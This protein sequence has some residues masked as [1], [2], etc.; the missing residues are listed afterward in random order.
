MSGVIA[1]AQIRALRQRL[2]LSQVELAAILGVSN[3]TVNRWEHE[4]ALPQGGMSERLL[5]LER[6]GLDALHESAP[7]QRGNLPATFSPLVGRDADLESVAAQI[8]LNPLLTIVGPA[9]AGKTRLAIESGR[10]AAR[11]W[12]D[13]I[14]FVDLAAVMEP[15]AVIHAVAR[16][17][18][19]REVGR[20][21]LADRLADEF[22][23]R[24]LLLILDNCEHLLTACA[25]LVSPL[26][27]SE[28]ASRLLATS[29]VPL[30]APGEAVHVLQPLAPVD[31]IALF[32]QRARERLP[33]LEL[34][35]EQEQ[36]IAEICRRLDGL[37]LAIELAA[38]RTH[39]LSVEQIAG[40]LDRRFDLLRVSSATAPRQRALDMAIGWSYDLLAPAEAALFRRLGAFAGWCDLPAVEAV[41]ERADAIDLLD[42]LARQ[43]MI[44]VA[45]DTASRSARYRLLESLASYARRELEQSG[46]AAA[47]AARHAEYYAGLAQRLSGGLRGAS[48]AA[49]FAALDREYDNLIAALE[50]TLT[51]H[52]SEQA[53]V[54]AGALGSYWDRRGRYAEGSAWLE[55]SL[56]QEPVLPSAARA[57]AMNQLGIL[58]NLTG[59]LGAAEQTLAAAIDLAREI[60]D[61]E[62]EAR[63]LD[64]L[65]LVLVARREFARAAECHET[66]MAIFLA[67]GERGRAAMS[68]KHLGNIANLRGEYAVS[69]RAYHEAWSLVQG[70]GDLSA[71]AVIL[72]NLGD[73]ASRIGRYSRALGYFE[74]A[75]A[76]LRMIGDPDR[77]AADAINTA[78]VKIV[79]GEPEAALPLA[80]D[81]V[82]QFRAIGNKA[83]LANALYVQGAALAAVGRRGNGLACFRESLTLFYQLDDWI[84]VVYAVE[85][86]ARL[87]AEGGDASFA[88]LLLGGADVIRAE[89]QVAPYPLF[90]AAGTLAVIRAALG[91]DGMAA[92]WEDGQSLA[93]EEARRRGVAGR[94][95]GGRRPGL[96]ADA[97]ASPTSRAYGLDTLTPRQIDVLRLV[98]AGSSNREIGGPLGISDRTVERHLTAIFSALDVDRRSSAVA[99]AGALG[100]L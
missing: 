37:P 97:G 68:R 4:R 26:I 49:L 67:L 73:R 50:W 77:L 2:G 40:R 94:R 12:R 53:V 59:R 84:D 60:G 31:A 48:Q 57:A 34:D 71:E 14:W 92:Q 30:D 69:E 41:A 90:D 43:S 76:V 52:E 36:A 66:A 10:L 95:A 99:K 85:V 7:A 45:H 64:T 23:D 44:V 3:V 61:R 82:T 83:S 91:T 17:L 79:L 78:E 86:I 98:A 55:R 87:F 96:R 19:V 75:L 27:A 93:R 42:G 5:R 47:A 72:S 54:L 15:E 89:E 32:V 24:T 21:S 25:A 74:R 62:Q 70:T 46:E 28:S 38:A 11:R 63:A 81:A 22:R 18:G 39:V 51:A 16:V 29:R 1:G 13:G 65:G 33:D 6:D 9:G 100:L 35:D 8:A 20:K 58:L 56:A 88:A 80:D